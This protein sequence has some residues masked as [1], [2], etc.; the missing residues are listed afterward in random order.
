MVRLVQVTLVF[1]EAILVAQY[2]YQ[3]P[4]RLHCNFFTPT[5]RFLIELA[6]LHTSRFRVVPIFCVYLL[7]LMHNYNIW[8]QEVSLALSP[9]LTMVMA[10][11]LSIG[12][13]TLCLEHVKQFVQIVPFSNPL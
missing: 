6:G 5:Q 8:R 13:E 11:L 3:L 4:F 1:S 7:T 9:L 2:V 10:L 12:P